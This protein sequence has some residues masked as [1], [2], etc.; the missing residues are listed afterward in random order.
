MT[1]PTPPPY[2]YQRA[3][4]ALRNEKPAEGFGRRLSASLERADA[5]AAAAARRSHQRQLRLLPAL[6]ALSLLATGVTTIGLIYSAEERGALSYTQDVEVEHPGGEVVWL[7]L[8]L[9]THHHGEHDTTLHVEVPHEVPVRYDGTR[10]EEPTCGPSSCV[11]RFTL[12]SEPGTSAVQIG[13]PRPGR[14]PV[15]VNHRSPDAHVS[16][17]ITVHARP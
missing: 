6:G 11:H 3:L 12:S 7:D 9:T 10:H 17:S 1:H 13:V 16:E 8:E 2:A 15:K 5:Q 4:Q 14:W